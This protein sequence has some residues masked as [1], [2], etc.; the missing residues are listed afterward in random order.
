[1]NRE[2]VANRISDIFNPYYV[3]APFFLLVAIAS[4][5]S[6]TT[7]LFY[8]LVTALFFSVLPLWDINRR[9]RLKMVSDAHISRREDRIKPFLFSLVCAA[10]GVIAVHVIGAPPAVKAVSWMVVITGAVITATTVFWKI[11]LHAAGA[12]A[13]ATALIVL[14]GAIAAPACL[15]IPVVFWARLTLKKHTPAQLLTGS[16]AAAAIA[17]LVFW[18]FGLV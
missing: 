12:T 2:K 14:F 11:S 15:F 16:L 18:D 1:M 13:T 7:A 8:W 3:S 17:I 4:S 9:I 6:L 5:R 10:L